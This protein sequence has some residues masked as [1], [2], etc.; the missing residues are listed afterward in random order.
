MANELRTQG[1]EIWHVSAPTAVQKIGNITGYGDF[2]KQANPIITTNLDSLAVEKI[3]GLA[4]NGEL[5]LS[6][7]VDSK[8][9]AHQALEAKAGTAE[10]LEFCIGYSDG[11]TPPTAVAG[12][13]VPP[14]AANRTSAK[15][16]AGVTSYRETISADAIV[17]ATVT[18]AI[19]GA[20]TRVYK[21]P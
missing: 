3:S 10:R 1:T 13:I 8:S 17:T 14:T 7:N 2:G 21:T 16:L 18:L 11:T 9:I 20:I 5:S 4:D 15:F 6:I 12:A 19:S